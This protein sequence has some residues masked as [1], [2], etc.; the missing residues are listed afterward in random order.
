MTLIV[1]S[2]TNPELEHEIAG[3]LIPGKHDEY[4]RL[5]NQT[6]SDDTSVSFARFVFS[7][8]LQLCELIPRDMH[9]KRTLEWLK[10]SIGIRY[11]VKPI[12]TTQNPLMNDK[13]H[14]SVIGTCVNLQGQIRSHF[15]I[16]KPSM[17]EGCLFLVACPHAFMR[18]GNN[19]S[20]DPAVETVFS[21]FTIYFALHVTFIDLSS[22]K[23]DC[24]CPKSHTIVAITTVVPVVF[25]ET[26]FV[27]KCNR[28]GVFSYH[29]TPW[30]TSY[31][32]P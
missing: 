6:I 14:S 27:P 8:N 16:L 13:S 31:A 12:N 3:G 21:F 22:A 18:Q 17:M 30:M 20:T 15:S 10:C 32:F 25:H 9:W 11:I 23:V 29:I 26:I 24:I 4:L 28:C 7:S 19:L 5:W 2:E 1:V